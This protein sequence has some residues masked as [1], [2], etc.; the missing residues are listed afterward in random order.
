MAKKQQQEAKPEKE[1]TQ[2]FTVRIPARW[3]DVLRDKAHQE[4]R[5]IS[6][7]VNE[8]IKRQYELECAGAAR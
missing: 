7:L 8:A 3:H 6:D 5:H 1:P 2:A 4:R